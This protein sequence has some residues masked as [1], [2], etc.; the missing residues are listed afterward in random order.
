MRDDG[1]EIEIRLKGVRDRK[2]GSTHPR[3]VDRV[4]IVVNLVFI[5]NS[6]ARQ[7]SHF[8]DPRCFSLSWWRAMIEVSSFVIIYFTG[9]GVYAM[10]FL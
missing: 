1:L 7:R 8:F 10:M 5:S 4:E 3:F 2:V 9:H 6:G